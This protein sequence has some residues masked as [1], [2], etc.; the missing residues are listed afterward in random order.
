MGG[1]KVVPDI[2]I[3]AIDP[4]QFDALVICGGSGWNG[5]DAPRPYRHRKALPRR[6]QA[7]GR[8]LRRHSRTGAHG[9]LDTVSHTS[10]GVG[11]LDKTNY[12]GKLHYR[13]TPQAVSERGIVTA[14]GTSPV[15]FMAAVMKALGAADD[16]LAFYVG[17]HAAQ[18]AGKAVEAA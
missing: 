10:N 8:D 12:G 1:M 7:G 16:Q 3:D 2:A 17:L 4:K 18:Y 13:D 5:P 14:P 6:P 15:S 11:Y 9:L